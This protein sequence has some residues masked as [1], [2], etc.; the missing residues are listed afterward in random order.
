MQ[1]TFLRLEDPRFYL[2]NLMLIYHER[3]RKRKQIVK[4]K[5]IERKE[6]GE[7][8]VEEKMQK[9]RLGDRIRMQRVEMKMWAQSMTRKESK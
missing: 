8:R 7:I 4:V 2:C 5:K 1:S 3:V 6:F 9:S